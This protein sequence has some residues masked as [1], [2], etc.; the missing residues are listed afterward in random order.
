[1]DWTDEGVVIARRRHG[2]TAAVVSLLTAAQGRHAG[3]VHGGGGR[4]SGALLQPGTRVRARWR[5]RLADHLGTFALEPMESLAAPLLDEPSAL[6]ALAAVTALVESACPERESHPRLYIETL[7]LLRRLAAP[8]WAVAY[9]H[10]ELAL[11]AELGFG[12]DLA[13][14]PRATGDLYLSLT[15]GQPVPSPAPDAL[16]LPAFLREASETAPA[17]DLRDA[18]TLSG[19][20]LERHA[21]TPQGRPLPQARLRLLDRLAR[22]ARLGSSLPTDSH[23]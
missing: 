18:L 1:M 23:A 9:V 11:L 15:T 21:L 3:L 12:I 22:D 13:A 19:A 5:A 4:R 17:R 14:P 7:S 2:E 10:W 20:F 16:R 8:G 6:A